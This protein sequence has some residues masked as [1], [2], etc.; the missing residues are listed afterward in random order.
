MLQDSS[1]F[2]LPPGAAAATDGS[3]GANGS[4]PRVRRTGWG[5][6]ASHP[7]GWP[8]CAAFGGVEGKQTV[9]RAELMAL[10]HLAGR[11]SGDV[12]VAV[13]SNYV[14]LGFAKGPLQPHRHHADLWPLLWDIV[15]GR[16]GT[17]SL[18]KVKAQREV[19]AEEAG[20]LSWDQV[21]NVWADVLAGE[22]ARRHEVS[23][24]AVNC[25]R[26]ADSD[27]WQIQS[28][29]ARVVEFVSEHGPPPPSVEQRKEARESTRAR[30]RTVLEEAIRTTSH[31]VRR[32][33]ARRSFSVTL[34]ISALPAE[35]SCSGWRRPASRPR[36][37]PEQ[38]ILRTLCRGLMALGFVPDAGRGL[39][40]GSTFCARFVQGPRGSPARQRL[41]RSGS[42]GDPRA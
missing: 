31:A 18:R 28:R 10:V 32:L 39:L 16:V 21:L 37:A 38:C 41:E 26:Q 9:A 8:V 29:L 33:G 36:C 40:S 25:L 22:A 14:V 35:V 17:I 15:R 20:S 34:V 7:G 23:P 30:R 24:Q 6:I 19:D 11:T 42:T 13:D 4:D 5:F 2:V 12:V 1:A 27:T 3:G